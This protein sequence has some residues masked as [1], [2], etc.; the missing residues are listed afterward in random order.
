MGQLQVFG[1]PPFWGRSLSTAATRY[2]LDLGSLPPQ[3]GIAADLLR[4]SRCS[5]E[6]QDL[7]LRMTAINPEARPTAAQVLQD[8]CFNDMR[9]ALEQ[10]RELLKGAKPAAEVYRQAQ[11]VALWVCGPD[12]SAA[13]VAHVPRDMPRLPPLTQ[14]EYQRR[15]AERRGAVVEACGAGEAAEGGNMLSKAPAVP[16]GFESRAGQQAAR[17]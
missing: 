11:E 14:A 13:A 17:G 15:V 2:G 10:H 9:G 1:T 12:P 4:H 16:P 3:R 5:P 7:I 8:D 6:L